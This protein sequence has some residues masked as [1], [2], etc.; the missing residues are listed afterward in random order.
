MQNGSGETISPEPR[1]DADLV[2]LLRGAV[3]EARIAG[4]ER[5][6]R[7]GGSG[8]GGKEGT[9]TGPLRSSVRGSLNV[10]GYSG[11]RAESERECRP[12]NPCD[13]DDFDVRTGELNAVHIGDGGTGGIALEQRQHA[14]VSAGGAR[15]NLPVAAAGAFKVQALNRIGG[16]VSHGAVSGE[17]EAG[18]R[19]GIAAAEGELD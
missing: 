2:M 7:V 9:L 11:H 6:R 17:G 13:A 4:I 14:A 8:A 16:R 10:I 18:H 19:A 12:R 5:S 15:K 3:K 1:A